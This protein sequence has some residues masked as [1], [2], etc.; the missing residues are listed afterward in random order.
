M[1]GYSAHCIVRDAGGSSASHPGWVGQERIK[2]AITSLIRIGEC[3][4]GSD[5]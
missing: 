2:A 4:T 1:A 3:E 5:N